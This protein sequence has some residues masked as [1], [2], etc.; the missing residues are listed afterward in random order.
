M[1]HLIIPMSILIEKVHSWLYLT[2]CHIDEVVKM[3]ILIKWT[4]QKKHVI[5]H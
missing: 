1:F 3:V 2:K 5:S 4:N